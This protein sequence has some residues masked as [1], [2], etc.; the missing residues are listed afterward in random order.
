[1]VGIDP[2][3]GMVRDEFYLH[4]SHPSADR[5]FRLA[6]VA[7][8][9]SEDIKSAYAIG[10]SPADPQMAIRRYVE[11]DEGRILAW[12][13]SESNTRRQDI[14]CHVLL[15]KRIQCRYPNRVGNIGRTISTA[16][17]ESWAAHAKPDSAN[18]IVP[19]LTAAV[20]KPEIEV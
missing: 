10:K 4:G 11:F 1:M 12:D 20:A 18:V 5:H 2:V 9:R 8:I 14:T 6:H 7:P 13:Y 15:P 3:D 17:R 19:I 16:N